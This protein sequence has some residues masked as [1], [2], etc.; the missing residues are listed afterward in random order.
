VAPRCV[1]VHKVG[2]RVPAKREELWVVLVPATLDPLA[3]ERQG[4]TALSDAG[5]GGRRL[6]C[7]AHSTIN[8]GP[9]GVTGAGMGADIT[10]DVGGGI[11]ARGCNENAV[12][13]VGHGRTSM[14]HGVDVVSSAV[15]ISHNALG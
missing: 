2:G 9:G 14:V 1:V 13:T 7:I 12:M 11:V 10:S 15:S 8:N 4:G 6:R 3:E 5:A